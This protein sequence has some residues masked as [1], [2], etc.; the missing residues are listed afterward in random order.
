M[1]SAA[2]I[3]GDYGNVLFAVRWFEDVRLSFNPDPA[4]VDSEVLRDFTKPF[5]APTALPPVASPATVVSDRGAVL[6]SA[7]R[8]IFYRVRGRN[9]SGDPGPH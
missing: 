4:A 8:E 9:C 5:P 7:G 2:A 6:E 3:P 1:C